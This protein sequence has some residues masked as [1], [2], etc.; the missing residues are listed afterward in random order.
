MTL[1]RLLV[2]NRTCGECNVCCI[3]LRIEEPELQKKADVRC[4]NLSEEKG[5]SIYNDRPD[6]CRTWYC[7]WR[8]LPFLEDDMRP[9]RTRV[10]IK[11]DGSRFTFQPIRR[12]GSSDLLK[13]NVMNAIATLVSNDKK[14]QLS[15]PTRPG[16]TNA[17]SP[18]NEVIKP[19]LQ[20]MDLEE[21]IRAINKTIFFA[22]RSL[23]LQEK[24]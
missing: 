15:V 3:A 20:T 5:C 1:E 2:P 7:G 12:E 4:P 18:V 13:M 10:L 16:F 21:G 6:V 17:L 24:D 14:V 19:S 11:F 8:I 9:D 22:S 23:T